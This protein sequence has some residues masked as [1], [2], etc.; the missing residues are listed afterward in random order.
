MGKLHYLTALLI[1]ILLAIASGWIFESIDK[2]PIRKNEKLRHDPDYFLKGFTSTTMDNS[3]KPAYQVKAELLQHYPDDDSMVLQQPFFSFYENNIKNWTAQSNEAIVL[4]KSDNIH[5]NG[6]VVLNQIVSSKKN[7]TPVKII[8]DQLTIEPEKNIAHTKSK[9]KLHKGNS[10]IQSLGMRADISKNRIEF[11]SRTRSH[12]VLQ[13]KPNQQIIDIKAQYLLHDEKRGVSQYKGKVIFT[14][15]TL[16]I[17][18]E[19]ITLHFKEEKLSKAVITG[20]P[21]DVQHQPENEEKVH[22]QANEIEYVVAE[23]KLILKGQAFVDQGSRHFS[24]EYIE[25]DTRQHTLSASGS[26]DTISNKDNSK[27]YPPNGR[28]HV[29][30]GPNDTREN[31]DTLKD[32]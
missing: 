10:Y 3:G 32:E 23:D 27:N 7:H 17:K 2:S 24:G 30:I 9:I 12:Y 5:L 11:L 28:V 25:Y 21:A 4:Q 15:G 1:I 13:E 6:G 31:K 22:S 16:T 19:V 14:K 18:A 8:T 26:K 20:S 29:I